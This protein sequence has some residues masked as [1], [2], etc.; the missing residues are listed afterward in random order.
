[1]DD[2]ELE[3]LADLDWRAHGPMGAKIISDNMPIARAASFLAEHAAGD[4]WPDQIPFFLSLAGNRPI[5]RWIGVEDAYGADG[6]PTSL[7]HDRLQLALE[8]ARALDVP[9][10][11]TDAVTAVEWDAISIAGARAWA[12]GDGARH[13]WSDLAPLLAKL[14]HDRRIETFSRPIGGSEKE[15][16]VSRALWKIDPDVAI[17]RLAHCGYDPNRPFDKGARPT[18][19]LFVGAIGLSNALIDAARDNYIAIAFPEHRLPRPVDELAPSSRL[20]IEFL[21][22]LMRENNSMTAETLRGRLNDRFAIEIGPRPFA[23]M[24]RE[25]FRADPELAGIMTKRRPGQI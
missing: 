20:Q 25:V 18:H 19:S 16:P 24:R 10:A 21:R 11:A 14:A 6:R 15:W 2:A 23:R 7:Y 1:M 12:E 17:V 9:L 3:W 5:G 4:T 8:H 22:T 13:T